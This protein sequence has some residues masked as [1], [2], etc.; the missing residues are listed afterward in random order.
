MPRRWK[1][2]K[3]DRTD[4]DAVRREQ[5]F[6]QDLSDILE[7]GTEND[8]VAA[9][10]MHKPSMGKEELRMLIMRFRVYAREKRGLC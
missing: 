7:Y 5:E 1:P 3:E 8:F 10:K 9:L 6:Q 2:P 4:A